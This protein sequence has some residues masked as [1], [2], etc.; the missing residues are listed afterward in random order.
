[1]YRLASFFLVT[2]LLCGIAQLAGEIGPEDS[3]LAIGPIM[4]PNGLRLAIGPVVEP[5][6]HRLTIGPLIEPNG[7][8][9]ALAPW[10]SRTACSLP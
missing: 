8:R 1:M 2:M 4:E 7:L 10:R 5:H 3:Q 6:G 9:L